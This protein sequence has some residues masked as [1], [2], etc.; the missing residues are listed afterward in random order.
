MNYYSLSKK[1]DKSIR[2]LVY[3]ADVQEAAVVA[4][5]QIAEPDEFESRLCIEFNDNS[6]AMERA[7]RTEWNVEEVNA[8]E[9]M[10]IVSEHVVGNKKLTGIIL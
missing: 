4:Y 9:V 8:A 7:I 1:T 3:A 10:T 5:E 6:T 2:F